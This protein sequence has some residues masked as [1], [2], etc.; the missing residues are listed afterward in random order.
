MD[1]NVKSNYGKEEKDR[2]E[3]RKEMNKIVKRDL[4]E[5]TQWCSGLRFKDPACCSYLDL[6][7]G[8]GTSICTQAKTR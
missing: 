6:I 4:Q 5:F 3:G 2:K 8:L 7:P 1:F